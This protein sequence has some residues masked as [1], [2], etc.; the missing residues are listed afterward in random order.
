LI[1]DKKQTLPPA[2][3]VDIFIPCPFVRIVHFPA[4]A[5]PLYEISE[6]I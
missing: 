5:P 3:C 1:V 6:Q 4:I 2:G